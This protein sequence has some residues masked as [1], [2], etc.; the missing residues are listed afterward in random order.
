MIEQVGFWIMLVAALVGLLDVLVRI[1]NN[2][3]N[4]RR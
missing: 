1:P 3:K 4:Q 2:K